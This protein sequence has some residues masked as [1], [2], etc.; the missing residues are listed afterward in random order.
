MELKDSILVTGSHRSGSTWVGRVLA[1]SG[2]IRYVQEPFNRETNPELAGYR[3]NNMFAHAADEATAHL[4]EHYLAHLQLTPGERLLIKDPIAVFSAPWMQ[5][6]FRIKVVCLVRHPAAFVSSLLKWQW[7][8][9]FGYLT[10]QPQ[11]MAKLRP[12][13]REQVQLFARERQEPLDQACLLWNVIYSWVADLKPTR[14]KWV[15]MTYE[16]LAEQPVRRFRRL[17]RKLGL[18]WSSQIAAE[19]EAM[20]GLDQPDET[21]DPGFKSR[22]ARALKS[23]WQSRL[24]PDQI[25]SIKRQTSPYWNKFYHK[26]HWK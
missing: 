16:S 5:D 10:A 7:E 23:V 9:H 25:E 24:H 17:F 18:S 15:L 8:F 13:L 4:K 22:N 3:L 12:E 2:E 11:L 1:L 21:D 26:K 19:I 14:R 6:T 20:S